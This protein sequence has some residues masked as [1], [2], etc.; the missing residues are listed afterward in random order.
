[1]ATPSKVP[2]VE[3]VPSDHEVVTTLKGLSQKLDVIQPLLNKAQAA[4]G[5]MESAQKDVTDLRN[6][7]AK[8]QSVYGS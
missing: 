4:F 1:M 6:R 8:A 5:G 7:I 2:P 3:G